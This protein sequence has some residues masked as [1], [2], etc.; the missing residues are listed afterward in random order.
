[1]PTVV[2]AFWAYFEP[3]LQRV[4]QNQGIRGM[5]SGV[6]RHKVAA[7]ADD[8]FFYITDLLTSSPSL[9]KELHTY[10]GISNFKV[11][12]QKSVAFNI[13]ISDSMLSIPYLNFPFCWANQF[14]QYLGKKILQL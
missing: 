8:L 9:L 10:G 7:C 2:P 13:S 11:N 6:H 4:R 12:L 1:M 5:V 14:I 3:F